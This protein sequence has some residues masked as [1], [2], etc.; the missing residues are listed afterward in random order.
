MEKQAHITKLSRVPPFIRFEVA[1][2]GAALLI[3]SS[4]DLHGTRTE[5]DL[6]ERLPVLHAT[7]E[8]RE[9]PDRI[10]DQRTHP[11]YNPEFMHR[12]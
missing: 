9:T 7:I 10:V 3:L 2:D 5:L 1:I 11:N 6:N 8:A 12:T 4:E